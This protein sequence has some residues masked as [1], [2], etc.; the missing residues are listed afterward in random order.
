MSE[1]IHQ[2]CCATQE[3]HGAE[4]HGKRRRWQ[5]QQKQEVEGL[6]G[7]GQLGGGVIKESNLNEMARFGRSGIK[8]EWWWRG[9]GG[10]EGLGVPSPQQQQ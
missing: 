7:G 3:Q 1:N 10:V 8:K 4:R 2:L 6:D 9:G 5:R